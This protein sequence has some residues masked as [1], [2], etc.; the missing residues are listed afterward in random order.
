MVSY[1][2]RLRQ[3]SVNGRMSV[4]VREHS[5]C[6]VSERT[7]GVLCAVCRLMSRCCW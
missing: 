4:S 6:V 7:V 5:G 1:L 3:G 2:G